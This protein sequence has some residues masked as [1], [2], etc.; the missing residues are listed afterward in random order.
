MPSAPP[1]PPPPSSNNSEKKKWVVNTDANTQDSA[2][3]A[4]QVAQNKI[5]T[6]TTTTTTTTWSGIG[7]NTF[8]KSSTGF[9]GLANQGT[10]CKKIYFHIGATCYLNSLIQSLY[11]TPEVRR[12]LYKWQYYPA[13]HGKENFCIPL[14]LQKL[15]GRLQLSQE[16]AISTEPLTE[17]FRWTKADSFVQHVCCLKITFC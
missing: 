1:P 12:I 10:L 17:S 8:E 14:Q 6:A 11:M 3:A 16:R 7:S 2:T 15:F 5:A 9:V 4:A 13:S